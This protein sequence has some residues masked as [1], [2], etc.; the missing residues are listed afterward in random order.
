MGQL[1]SWGSGLKLSVE[2][3]V[4]WLLAT[5]IA[6]LG[7]W[8]YWSVHKLNV[9]TNKTFPKNGGQ[10]AKIMPFFVFWAGMPFSVDPSGQ[11]VDILC[12]QVST[13]LQWCK[14]NQIFFNVVMYQFVGDNLNCCFEEKAFPQINILG[15]TWS[16]IPLERL[17]VCQGCVSLV[18]KYSDDWGMGSLLWGSSWFHVYS[19]LLIWQATREM[20]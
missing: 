12:F 7:Q 18:L 10:K 3:H 13:R 5:V 8:Y 4:N 17:G 19:F 20:S 1:L 2:C 9:F 15:F 11:C 16:N 14:H 6:T